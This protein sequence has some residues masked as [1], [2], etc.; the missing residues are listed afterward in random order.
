MTSGPSWRWEGS[1]RLSCGVT[2]RYR[3]FLLVS[4]SFV[5]LVVLLAVL[6]L[7]GTWA[8]R[9]TA[10]G[11]VELFC[12]APSLAGILLAPFFFGPLV[13]GN[14]GNA[15]LEAKLQTAALCMYALAE[16]GVL[17]GVFVSKSQ[18][19]VYF[20]YG[21]FPISFLIGLGRANRLWPR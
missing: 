1:E 10:I 3:E 20:G 7:P 11:P 8:Q 6:I 21:A 16:L 12:A 17:I 2:R 19:G 13:Y 14:G 5:A 15:P 4:F 18:Y 9:S